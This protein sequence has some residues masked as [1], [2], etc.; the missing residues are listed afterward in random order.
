M[1][2]PRASAEL[3][4]VIADQFQHE[5][6]DWPNIFSSYSWR[7]NGPEQ[8][9]RMLLDIERPCRSIFRKIHLSEPLSPYE[10]TELTKFAQ[11]VFKWGGVQRSN[12]Q[13]AQNSL[14][15][16]GVIRAALSWKVP[17]DS[18]PMNSGW[19]KVAALA[20]EFV[21]IK[22]GAPQV[23][24]DSRV[25]ASLLTRLDH[26]LTNIPDGARPAPYLPQELK[27]LGYVPGRG[28]T[29]SK[30]GHR[31]HRLGWPNRYRRWD[32][33]FAASTLVNEI[34]NYLNQ[35]IERYGK[36]PFSPYCDQRWSVR[37]V[38]MVLFMDG[39]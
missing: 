26:V 33:Q 20:T 4:S 8:T 3:A 6:K 22:G 25:A 35:N 24:F 28:G 32:A 9:L 18:V 16:E 15:V 1:N 12:S 23:I 14:V 10:R 11:A 31:A 29:R 13:A 38:E 39:Q 37:G 17:C 5:E 34:R 30:H 36:M 2:H 19:T 21:E 27:A 7:S